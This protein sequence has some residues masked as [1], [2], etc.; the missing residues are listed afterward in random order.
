VA[1]AADI[2]YLFGMNLLQGRTKIC[3]DTTKYILACI[4]NHMINVSC[5]A[6]TFSSTSPTNLWRDP[7]LAELLGRQ[8]MVHGR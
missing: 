5:I 4:D 2:G 3:I 1:D 8:T 6:F 7:E